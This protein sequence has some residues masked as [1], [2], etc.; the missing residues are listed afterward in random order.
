MCLLFFFLMKGMSCEMISSFLYIV[1]LTVNLLSA[2]TPNVITFSFATSTDRT[3]SV[4]SSFGGRR[5]CSPFSE[6]N[7]V[8]RRKKMS[9][10][11]DMSAVA[12]VFSFGKR[13]CRFLRP[14]VLN[15]M[16]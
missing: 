3:S 6:S 1:S 14:F 7:D 13:R 9:N 16:I 2:V 11:K 12:V 8:V 4:A 15:R 5:R 10:M